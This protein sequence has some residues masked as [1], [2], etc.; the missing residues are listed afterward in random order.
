MSQTLH[1]MNQVQN[2]TVKMNQLLS[3]TIFTVKDHMT[4]RQHVSVSL[5]ITFETSHDFRENWYECRVIR[6]PKK[7]C[8]RFIVKNIN[9]AKRASK[10]TSINYNLFPF[11]TEQRNRKIFMGSLHTVK[12]TKETVPPPA[13]FIFKKPRWI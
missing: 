8:L 11:D 9:T 6:E 5:L 3:Q 1:T 12:K 7:S 2:K 10:V 13:R 4:S